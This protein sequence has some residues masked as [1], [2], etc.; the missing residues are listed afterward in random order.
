MEMKDIVKNR[1]EVGE[2]EVNTDKLAKRWNDNYSLSQWKE[3]F[4]LILVTPKKKKVKFKFAIKKSNA[5]ELIER[6]GLTAEQS[7]V[8][9]SGKTWRQPII[10]TSAI[11]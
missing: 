9:N 11:I 5:W 2:C 10:Q 3:D 8:F 1:V 4:R 7:P 6:L